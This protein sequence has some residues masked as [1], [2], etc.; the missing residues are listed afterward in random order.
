MAKTINIIESPAAFIKSTPHQKIDSHR[1]IS[2][3]CFF[4]KYLFFQEL[5]GARADAVGALLG[6]RRGSKAITKRRWA[7]EVPTLGRKEET[8]SGEGSLQSFSGT[9]RKLIENLTLARKRASFKPLNA[10][11]NHLHKLL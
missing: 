1:T 3:I 5:V 11:G 6:G 10:L 7:E 2:R 8:V 9:D 4:F